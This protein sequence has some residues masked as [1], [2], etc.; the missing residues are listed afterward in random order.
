[1]L[2]FSNLVLELINSH[3]MKQKINKPITILKKELNE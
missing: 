2:C 1:M 3:I